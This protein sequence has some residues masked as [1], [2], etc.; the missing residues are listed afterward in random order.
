M[1]LPLTWNEDLFTDYR[2]SEVEQ[3]VKLGD[4]REVEVRGEGTIKLCVT[5]SENKTVSLTLNKVLHVPS[6]KC[7]LF[8][9]RVVTERGFQVT[10][11]DKSCHI[12]TKDDTVIASGDRQGNLYMLNGTVEPRSEP[13]EAAHMAATSDNDIW[14]QRLGHVHE[15]LL[16]KLGDGTIVT[17][18]KLSNNCELSV[19]GGCAMGKSTRSRPKPKHGLTTTRRLE[20][21]HSDVCGPMSNK[22]IG[23]ATYMITF[24]D[25]YTR[26]SS[27]YFM[28]HK[29]E[30]LDKFRDYLASVEGERGERVGILHADN[31]GE[32]VSRGFKTF[33][34]DNRIK[35]ETTLPYNPE[36]NGVSERLNRT[37]MDRA[38]TLIAHADLPK[39]YWAEAVQTALFITN[40]LPRKLL[41]GNTPFQA[42]YGRKP[43]M[44]GMRVFGCMAYVHVPAE[45]RCKLDNKAVQARFVGYSRGSR[46][47][48][49]LDEENGKVFHSKDVTFDELRFN[50]S[51]EETVEPVA[52]SSVTLKFDSS[53]SAVP[54]AP[55]TQPVGVPKPVAASSSGDSNA[56]PSRVR[57]ATKRY[58][59][60]E[61]YLHMHELG[62]VAL[63]AGLTGEPVSMSQALSGPD[64]DEW[65]KAAEEEY[66]SLLDHDTWDLV[67]P[68]PHRS[69]VGSKWIFKTKYDGDG[70]VDRHKCRLVAQGFSQ[71]EGLDY[72][73]T[74]A[75]VA[76]L[77]TI[78]ALIALGV[79]RNMQMHQM[80]VKTAF[81][82]GKLKEDIFMRQPEG[83]IE[84]GKE[85]LVCHLKRSIYGLK[86]SP[87]CWYE[88]LYI[89]LANLSFKQC[90]FDPCVFY[91]WKD[92]NLIIITVYVDDLILMVDKITDL[93]DLKA[94][95][96]ERFRMKDLG[97]LSYCLGLK[98]HAAR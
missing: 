9:V 90:Q 6:M 50:R 96:S 93:L 67:E 81:L 71:K 43:D 16:R 57:T 45:K 38:R 2:A 80:D 60:D 74:F 1:A 19:C 76:R 33:L 55:A 64:A 32:Y 49:L 11:D 4:G 24:T 89:H 5:R 58:G 8:S 10:F 25:D 44:S 47:Y 37:L 86:Q 77:G 13:Q 68:P 94:D 15:Q 72:T 20:R 52:Q 40:R 36:M 83:F 70:Q 7:N 48:K 88:E 22:F 95:L 34:R 46:G 3:T 12:K 39:R 62:H 97:K 73:E 54:P 27:V 31:G 14:H 42:W 85:H 51:V 63:F 17:G 69:I 66:Q 84:P 92:G 56:Q 41:S 28:K 79:H 78:R 23:G 75:P 30:A 65:R 21:V 18:V 29:S 35:L 61:L 98:C 82:N 59:I 87:R 91:K 26:C 53:Q